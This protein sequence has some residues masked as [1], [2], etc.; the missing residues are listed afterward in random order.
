L[1]TIFVVVVYN[2]NAVVLLL[3]DTTNTRLVTSWLD[4]SVKTLM[5]HQSDRLQMKFSL[6][7]YHL[8]KNKQCIVAC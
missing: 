1:I 2:F 4:C 6:L 3:S 8:S 7:I 5:K